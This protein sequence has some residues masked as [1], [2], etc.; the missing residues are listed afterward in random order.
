M[1]LR[2]GCPVPD[3][4]AITVRKDKKNKNLLQLSRGTGFDLRRVQDAIAGD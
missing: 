1:P 3:G 4:G 2:L